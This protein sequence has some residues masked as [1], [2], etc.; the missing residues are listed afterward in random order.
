MTGILTP[1]LMFVR[2]CFV[3]FVF[4]LYLELG[5]KAYALPHVHVCH[6]RNKAGHEA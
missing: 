5:H 1:V 3:F 4:V 6:F 2:S